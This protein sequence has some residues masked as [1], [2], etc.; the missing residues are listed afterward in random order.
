M[1]LLLAL[2]ITFFSVTSQAKPPPE[3]EHFAPLLGNWLVSGRRL[4]QDGQSWKENPHPALWHFYRILNG[5]G[6]QDDWTS[7]A[8]HIAVAETTRTYGTN[9]RIFNNTEGQWEMAW[10]DSTNQV[11]RSFTA[12]STD[13]QII[14]K[15]V[16]IDPPRRN[17]FH[18]MSSEGFSWRQEWTFDDGK[19]WTP[20]SYLE[21][22]PWK[23]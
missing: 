21:A 17:I 13:D 23:E 2:A 1:K 11:V 16:G 22:T 7:P 19:T 18:N 4:S 15:S 6:I 12:T 8:P 10:I 9:I 14:M 20:V 3:S 5:H